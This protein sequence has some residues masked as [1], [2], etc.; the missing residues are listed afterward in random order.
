MA[1]KKPRPTYG[2]IPQPPQAV[3]EA[4]KPEPSPVASK[5][6]PRQKAAQAPQSAIP[7]TP[8][9]EV[10]AAKAAEV[11]APSGPTTVGNFGAKRV[12]WSLKEV[13]EQLRAV[14]D[15]LVEGSQPREILRVLRGRWPAMTLGRVEKLAERVRIN[16]LGATTEES[17]K[18]DRHAAIQRLHKMRRI[19]SGLRDKDGKWVDRPNHQA[20][21]RYESLLMELEGT[22]EAIRVDVNVRHTQAMLAVVANLSGDEASEYLAEAL[23]QERLARIAQEAVPALCLPAGP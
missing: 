20:V 1:R 2:R 18:H 9:P 8:A 14:E 3:D 10:E 21:A 13:R 16:W 22:R 11:L 7:H 12:A 15:F 17:R 4:A 19:A 5:P 23:E 6:K